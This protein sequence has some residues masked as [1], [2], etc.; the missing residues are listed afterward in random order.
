MWK[1]CF[2]I[3]LPL[4][5]IGADI[6]VV[7]IDPGQYK[8]L[9]DAMIESAKDHDDG[10]VIRDGRRVLEVFPN[11]PEVQA[12][13]YLLMADA[14]QSLGETGRAADYRALATLLNLSPAKKTDGALVR[15]D[16]S[17][18]IQTAVG[19]ITQSVS[20]I[21]QI[22][23]MKLCLDMVKHNMAP[24][25]QCT[26]PPPGQLSVQPMNQGFA[27][28]P[29]APLPITPLPMASLPIAPVP[30][31]PVPVGPLPLDPALVQQPFAPAPAPVPNTAIMYP[32]APVGTP[33][34]Q[35][36]SS[37]APPVPPQPL[38]PLQQTM[39]QISQQRQQQGYQQAGMQA[40][41]TFGQ[42]RSF[43]PYQNRNYQPRNG[44]TRGSD[45]PVHRVIRDF[46]G[47]GSANYF[48][49]SCGALLSTSGENLTLT[50]ACGDPIIIPANEILELRVN[51]FAGKEAG[52]FHIS[53]KQGLYMNLAPESGN[54]EDARSLIDSVRKQLSLTE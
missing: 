49:P 11:N 20:L 26:A 2:A 13:V 47:I 29:I 6:P 54:R 38:M 43:A 18:T 4:S 45:T 7:R 35:P 32:P 3:C 48:E 40:P 19:A 10:A 16:V 53:T 30:I 8:T 50:T 5:L 12:P 28:Q 51:S 46:S 33:A 14:L 27:P 34:Y 44:R 9:T 15:G 17:S 1:A 52:M 22:Q 39:Q 21:Q 41:Q 42:N 36:A 23:L 25:P 37:Y 31:A 24:P